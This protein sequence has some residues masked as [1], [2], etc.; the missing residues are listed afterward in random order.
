MS[1]W[2]VGQRR[3]PHSQRRQFPH[4]RFRP[5]TPTR[6]AQ[7]TS[8][9]L[10]FS[11]L[12]SAFIRPALAFHWSR[13][14]RKLR[15]RIRNGLTNS[16]SAISPT[17]DTTTA[18]ITSSLTPQTDARRN[19][20]NAIHQTANTPSRPSFH[21]P[22]AGARGLERAVRPPHPSPLPHSTH[23]A[24]NTSIAGGGGRTLENA[25]RESF[26]TLPA[27]VEEWARIPRDFAYNHDST[28]S[29]DE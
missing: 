5:F 7:R 6:A 2:S 9:T 24:K 14:H 8:W 20:T 27:G 1:R 26:T 21:Q 22:R 12:T 4:R 15:T 11:R 23:R 28:P 10:T 17:A 16:R 29:E 13:L 18:I 19:K 3:H 25:S